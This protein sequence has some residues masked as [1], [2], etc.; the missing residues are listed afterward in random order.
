MLESDDTV[1]ARSL[2]RRVGL[3]AASSITRDPARRAFVGSVQEQQR[4][5]RGWVE[6]SRKVSTANLRRDL[7]DRDADLADMN[8]KVQLLTASHKA[9][10]LALDEMGG[11]RAWVKFFSGYAAGLVTIQTAGAIPNTV[12][13]PEPQPPPRRLPP[14]RP[15]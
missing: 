5:R 15:T 11:T 14:R 7:A 10:L 12:A 1:T 4:A 8:R 13:L 3:R 6:R 9:I 2:A